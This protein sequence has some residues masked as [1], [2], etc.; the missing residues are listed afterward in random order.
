MLV[1]KEGTTDVAGTDAAILDSV[2]AFLKTQGYTIRTASEEGT[3]AQ[4]QIDEGFKKGLSEIDGEI[5]S[6]A[7]TDKAANEKTKDYPTRS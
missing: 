6:I 5:K 2:R 4:A 3:F 7:G 1:F